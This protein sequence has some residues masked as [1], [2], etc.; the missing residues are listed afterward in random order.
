MIK[1]KRLSNLILVT[2]L[3][4]SMSLTTCSLVVHA[5]KTEEVTSNIPL[6]W[7]YD[8]GLMG[9]TGVESEDAAYSTTK[10]ITVIEGASYTVSIS[11]TYNTYVAI[12]YYGS[13]GNFI[14][15]Q[16]CWN[17]SN[18][19][20]QTCDLVLPAG[21][22]TFRIMAGTG[23]ESNSVNNAVTLAITLT[24]K[25]I[26]TLGKSVEE[27]LEISINGY[28]NDVITDATDN[29]NQEADVLN[30]LEEDLMNDSNQYVEDY[31]SEA[32]NTS[33]LETL[34]ASLIF[35]VT[36][37]TNF[38]NMGGAFTSCLN[39]LLALTVVFAIIKVR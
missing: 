28:D 32:F 17:I 20:A 10:S 1:L 4:I 12:F 38:W 26:V 29:F 14:S 27:L 30:G 34:G 11:A 21:A 16:D 39:F 25:V 3:A 24:E 9:N 37:F 31:T 18:Q 35:V 23:K 2:L 36:W 7:V 33:F 13:S 6:E 5:E 19:S 22:S 8:V 15:K